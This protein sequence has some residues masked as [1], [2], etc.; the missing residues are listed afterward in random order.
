MPLQ[1]PQCPASLAPPSPK[2]CQA[3]DPSR[4]LDHPRVGPEELKNISLNEIWLVSSQSPWKATLPVSDEDQTALVY[5]HKTDRMKM[6]P[7]K[8]ESP[9]GPI[10][11]RR[12]LH[13]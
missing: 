13:C 11:V 4:S 2:A 10:T 7:K 1:G 6:V 9:L 12:Y 8:H 5:A 3:P